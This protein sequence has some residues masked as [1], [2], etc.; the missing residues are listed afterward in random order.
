MNLSD[1]VHQ[2][3]RLGILALLVPVE[4]CDFSFLRDSLHLTNGNL[5][6]HLQVLEEAGYVHISKGFVGKKVR[7]SVGITD[8]GRQAFNHELNSLRALVAGFEP[9]DV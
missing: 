5:S 7:T 9:G 6:R 2:R 3:T 4:S 1:V 8:A